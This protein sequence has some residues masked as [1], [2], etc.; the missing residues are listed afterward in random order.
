MRPA[1]SPAHTTS[2]SS[3][4]NDVIQAE[5][6][7]PTYS[8]TCRIDENKKKM[9]LV[10]NSKVIEIWKKKTWPT[11]TSRT[12]GSMLPQVNHGNGIVILGGDK[13]FAIAANFA[14]VYERRRQPIE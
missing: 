1:L 4:H 8:L 9:E 14:L 10:N 5:L 7:P 12:H 3:A 2:S 11:D 13:Y 6:P